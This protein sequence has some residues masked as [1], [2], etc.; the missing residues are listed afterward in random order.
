MLDNWR[1][2]RPWQRLPHR[3]LRLPRLLVGTGAGLLGNL[4]LLSIP[5]NRT[6]LLNVDGLVWNAR[7]SDDENLHRLT[8]GFITMGS[9]EFAGDAAVIFD[10][11]IFLWILR[12][13]A[14]VAQ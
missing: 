14:R 2:G 5:G 4:P 1:E 13:N 6:C 11:D 9:L 8:C 3:R 7:L 10:T 12:G